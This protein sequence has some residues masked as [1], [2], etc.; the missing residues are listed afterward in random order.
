MDRGVKFLEQLYTEKELHKEHR[1]KY[2]IYKLSFVTTLFA[3]GSLDL[4][5]IMR[6]LIYLVPIVALC[7]DIYIFSED[8]K[9][10]RIGVFLLFA[11]EDPK[12]SEKVKQTISDME[13]EWEKWVKNHRD[14]WAYLASLI[15]TIVAIVGSAL[16]VAL[17]AF[18]QFSL[19]RLFLLIFWFLFM[20]VSII[21]VFYY[22]RALRREVSAVV[23][24]LK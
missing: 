6:S 17:D 3:L 21:L 11:K 5:N 13:I 23:E 19:H 18:R 9:V 15:I 22:G 20:I 12:V 10:K 8:Y 2:V 14:R 1:Y 4:G 7:Y 16:I 24:K